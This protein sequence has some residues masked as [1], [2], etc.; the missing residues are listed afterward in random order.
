[1]KEEY[2]DFIGI[3]DDSVPIELF[4]IFVK[5]YDEAKNNR[6]IIDIS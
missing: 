5:G 2:K 3:Y 6:S 1:M 4:N